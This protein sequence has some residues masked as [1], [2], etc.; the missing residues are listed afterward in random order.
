MS[1]SLYLPQKGKRDLQGKAILAA[2]IGGTKT[3]LGW[4]ELRNGTLALL[5]EATVSSKAHATF[6]EVVTNFLADKP[7]VPHILSIGVA[8]PVLDNQ[9]KLTNLSWELDGS[10]LERELGIG[11]TVLINDLEATAYGLIGLAPEDIAPVFDDGEPIQGNMVILA[12]GTGLGE[13]GLFW[14]GEAYRPFATEGGH[15]DFA[16]RTALDLELQAYLN[17]ES[18]IVSWEHVVSGPGIYRIYRFL[19]DVKGHKEPAWLTENFKNS[20][21]SAAVVS[22]AAMRELD[23][24]CAKAMDL[25][26]SFMAREATSLV[27]K[28][29]AVGG[30]LLGGGIPPRIYP[31]LRKELFRQQFI[32]NSHMKE[33]LEEVPI[34]VVLNSKAAL[35]GAAYFGAYGR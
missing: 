11:R 15:S 34:K 18:D 32:Q 31:L 12:P 29:K 25:F 27:L 5:Q 22:H 6:E 2:D 24:T 14:D 30:L 9:V 13:A 1:Y 23:A 35:I 33:L 10:R 21:D 19:R 16:P 28:H 20:N 4:F 8:G 17:E 7:D 3:S 26:V